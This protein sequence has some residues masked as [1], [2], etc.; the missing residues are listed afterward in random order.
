MLFARQKGKWFPLSLSLFFNLEHSVFAC[1][2][3]YRAKIKTD[4]LVTISLSLSL[5]LS[6]PLQ[7]IGHKKL[8]TGC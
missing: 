4:V 8:I 7:L 3:C 5:C 1:L 2:F 6:L